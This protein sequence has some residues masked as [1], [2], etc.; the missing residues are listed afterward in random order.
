M[1]NVK[2]EAN[3]HVRIV[4]FVEERFV[5]NPN[6]ISN[7]HKLLRQGKDFIWKCAHCDA[8]VVVDTDKA[9]EAQ[10]STC[11]FEQECSP[12]LNCS[13]MESVPIR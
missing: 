10:Y 4:P 5:K 9:E 7:G 11:L 2:K 8:R 6:V 12:E 3:R 1:H 13:E